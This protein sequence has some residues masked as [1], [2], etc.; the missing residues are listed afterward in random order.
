MSSFVT[1]ALGLLEFAPVIAKLVGGNDS[2]DVAERIVETAQS[3]TG[4][5]NR[6]NPPVNPTR[7]SRP[8]LTTSNPN[9]AR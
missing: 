3:L 9:T 8:S 4:L 5:F 2:G 1:M 6:C 7:A